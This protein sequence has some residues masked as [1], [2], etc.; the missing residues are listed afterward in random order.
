[1][2]TYKYRRPSVT[3]DCVVFGFEPP[4][5][6]SVLLVTRKANPFKGCRALPGGFLHVSDSGGQGESLETGALRELKEETGVEPGHLEQLYTFGAPKRDPRGRVIS[7]AHLALVRRAEH[8]AAPGSDAA[9]A[10]WVPISDAVSGPLAFDHGVILGMGLARL[11]AKARYAPIGFG[12]MPKQ[13]T[14][15]QLR[16]L[17]ETLLGRELNVSLFA[18]QAKGTGV[19]RET[20]KTKRN[21]HRPARLYEFDPEAYARMTERGTNFEL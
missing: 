21:G 10:E 2:P 5:T 6:L 8:I 20:G 1:M 12:L 4:R 14:I 13:F 17:Y 15:A 18:K 16:E 3:T 11:R 9:E 19:L 7:V